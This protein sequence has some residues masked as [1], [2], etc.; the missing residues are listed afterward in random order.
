MKIFA[1][2]DNMNT[3]SRN[4]LTS[5]FFY[6]DSALSNA[7]KPFFIP[8]S[9]DSISVSL[10]IAIKISR[11]GKTI[12]E[13]FS[14]RYYRELAPIIHFTDLTL[15]EK[16]ESNGLTP[17]PAVSFDKSVFYGEFKPYEDILSGKA[18][19]QLFINGLEKDYWNI[20]SLSKNISS[21]IKEIS[22][23][24][25]LK[26]GDLLIPAETEAL[27]HVYEGDLVEIRYNGD[28]VLKIKIK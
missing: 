3:S 23:M 8:E 24:N 6:A 7:G 2:R 19:F 5:W 27:H 10:G 18:S 11:L 9:G 26:I 21:L 28:T 4:N 17:T 14:N 20:D 12:E 1:V 22:V 13:R 25:T 16:L 15:Y